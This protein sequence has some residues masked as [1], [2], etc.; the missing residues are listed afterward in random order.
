[1]VWGA[2]LLKKYEADNVF[3][4][5]VTVPSWS[6]NDVANARVILSGGKGVS[7]HHSSWWLSANALKTN[8]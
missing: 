4:M 8:L 3:V 6:R 1:M 7:S 2:D 5:P